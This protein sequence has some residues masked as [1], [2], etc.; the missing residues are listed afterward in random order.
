MGPA[1]TTGRAAGRVA[2]VAAAAAAASVQA[3]SGAVADAVGGIQMGPTCP[4]SS[5]DGRVEGARP[6]LCRGDGGDAHE[7]RSADPES[8]DARAAEHAAAGCTAACQ[9]RLTSLFVCLCI[10]SGVFRCAVSV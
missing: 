9:S 3:A 8:R 7:E 6:Q 5:E 2:V 1:A 4:T 10:S